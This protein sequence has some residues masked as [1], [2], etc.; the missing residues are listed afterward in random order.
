MTVGGGKHDGRR[1]VAGGGF[2]LRAGV[3]L[4]P[5]K[6]YCFSW[7]LAFAR[8]TSPLMSCPFLSGIQGKESL[9][10]WGVNAT[11]KAELVFLDARLRKHDGEGEARMTAGERGQG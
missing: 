1:G 11:I 9:F 4:I 7:I 10:W 2:L 8:M 3:S 6:R 5:K